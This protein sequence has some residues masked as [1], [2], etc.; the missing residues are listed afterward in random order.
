ML[1]GTQVSAGKKSAAAFTGGLD[2]KALRENPLFS[3]NLKCK[4]V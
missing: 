4:R 2:W 3:F 1:P